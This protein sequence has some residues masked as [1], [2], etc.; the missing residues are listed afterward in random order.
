MSDSAGF[1]KVDRFRVRAIRLPMRDP[2]QTASGAVSESPLVLTDITLDDGTVGHSVIFTYTPAALEPTAALVRNF[3]AL[4][5]GDALAPAET[6]QKLAR[7]FRL[8]GPQG[9]VGMALAA[10]DMALWDA[11]ARLHGV[12]LTRLLGGA[13]KA[14]PAYGAV[15][16][17]GAAKSARVAEDWAKRGFTGVKA[18][19]GYPSVA[20]D[21]EVIRAM[22]EATGPGMAIM[23]DFN[24]SLTVAEAV[25]R[26]RVLDDEGLTW[27]EE[28]TLAHDYAG[29]AHVAREARTPI[30]CGEN[31]WGALDFWHAVEARASDYVM[32]DVMK[33]GG[34]TGWLR[35]ASI[36]QAKGIRM[37]NHLFPELSAQLLCVTPTAHWLEYA[38]WWNPIMEAP[39]EIV[40]G[41]THLTGATGSGVAWNEAA[42]QKY[43]A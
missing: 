1:P 16:Y 29:H 8:L 6:E 31:W 20:E 5:K 42:V 10:I 43:S 4:I 12:S 26:M 2:H 14:V 17:D 40:Q 7:R 18:K 34:V 41:M 35:A 15:G 36:A 21:V 27:V 30:Q 3:E 28:P 19:I 11:L 33:I 9:L 32:P 13:E 23:V 24:Q 25:Q 38:D 22:R 39:L 37:S